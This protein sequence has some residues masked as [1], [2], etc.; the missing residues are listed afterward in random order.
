MALFG[1][2]G[3]A[4]ELERW[5]RDELGIAWSLEAGSGL[6]KHPDAEILVLPDQGALLELEGRPEGELPPGIHRLRVA[7]TL[8]GT[9]DARHLRIVFYHRGDLAIEHRGLGLVASDGG[10]VGLEIR[11]SLLVR[12]PIKLRR[13]LLTADAPALTLAGLTRRLTPDLDRVLRVFV[14]SRARSDLPG[15]GRLP[16]ELEPALEEGLGEALDRLG[17]RFVRLVGARLQLGDWAEVLAKR[18]AHSKRSATEEL[19]AAEGELAQRIFSRETQEAL[20]R[21]KTTHERDR[22]LRDL[23]KDRLLGEAERASLVRQLAE[24]AALETMSAEQ[25]QAAMRRAFEEEMARKRLDF[26]LFETRSRFDEEQHRARA[27]LE[28]DRSRAMQE[29][30]VTDRGNEIQLKKL[31]GMQELEARMAREKHE[32]EREILAMRIQGVS[33]ADG[34]EKAGLIAGMGDEVAAQ[35]SVAQAQANAARVKAEAIAD[36]RK[37]GFDAALDAHR[38]ATE[39]MGKVASE[40]ARRVP[41]AIGGHGGCHDHRSA[42]GGRFCTHCGEPV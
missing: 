29:L 23:D 30:D 3:S 10:E 18:A 21:A 11:C 35:V 31:A 16:L 42:G 39:T 20:T 5:R 13:E 6:E 12:D 40:A 22:I 25:R 17:L 26:E 36:G 37:E 38:R 4:A 14:G 24:T 9:R 1:L 32:R 15:P 8:L 41:S 34:T 19:A 2:F 7:R 33:A 27:K 28:L